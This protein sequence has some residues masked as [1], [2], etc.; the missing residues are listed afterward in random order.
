[1]VVVLDDRL[2]RAADSLFDVVAEEWASLE[3]SKLPKLIDRTSFDTDV[4]ANVDDEQLSASA[5]HVA[6]TH[7]TLT[8][9]SFWRVR[10]RWYISSGPRANAC[11]VSLGPC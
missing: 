3:S 9:A 4:P 10:A 6:P 8:G 1:V 2:V 7:S 5:P 11:T